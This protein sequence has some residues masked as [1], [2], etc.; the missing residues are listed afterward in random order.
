MVGR[1]CLAKRPEIPRNV[2]A[3]EPLCQA[4]SALNVFPKE[5]GTFT[6][7]AIKLARSGLNERKGRTLSNDEIIHYQKILVVLAETILIMDEIDE[8][9]E[10]HGGW[11][12]AFL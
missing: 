10:H 1:Y 7:V 3:I 11:P 8:T 9:I 5:S 2:K 6:L 12:T 4:P